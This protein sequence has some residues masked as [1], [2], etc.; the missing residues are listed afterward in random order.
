LHLTRV[1]IEE[2]FLNG[3]DLELSPGLNVLIGARGT[4]KTSVIEL[5]RYAL[6]AKNHT[7]T[8]KVRSLDHARAV[9]SD[10]EVTVNLSDALGFEHVVV[11]RGAEDEAPRSTGEFAPPIVLS[12]TEVETLGLSEAGRLSLIDGFVGGRTTLKSEE[13]STVSSTRS[14]YQEISTL[15][16]ELDQFGE[17]M[18]A[19]AALTAQ[20]A[21]LKKQQ[22]RIQGQSK[23]IQEKQA[24]LAKHNDNLADLSV[25]I[26]YLTRFRTSAEEWSKLIER[27]VDDDFAPESWDEELT[28]DPLDGLRER[29]VT[30]K[31]SAAL[32]VR[33]FSAL[34]SLAFSRTEKTAQQRIEQEKI[35]RTLRTELDKLAEGSGTL[36]RQI[37]TLQTQIAQAQSREKIVA[38][39]KRRLAVLRSKRDE[40][41]A[42]LQ[43]TRERRFEARAN[44]IKTLNKALSPHIRIELERSAQYQDYTKAITNA[45]RGSGMKYAELATALSQRV[46]PRE[47]IDSVDSG[48]FALLAEL[49]DIPKD[50]AARLIGHIR[51]F[52]C[53]EIATSDVD[54]NVRM[55]L[56]DGTEYKDITS[57]SAGQRCTVILSIVLQHKERTLVIDQPEDHLDNAFVATTVIKALRGR[58]KSGQV[59]LSTHNANIPVLGDADLVV[60][61]TSD[62]RNGFLQLAR[63]LEHPE[64]VEAI[65]SV[66]EG[67]RDAFAQRAHFY[68]AHKT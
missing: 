65:T 7:A 43:G 30:A 19:I 2:G 13:A 22:S 57:L 10:G 52:G 21:E 24:I 49:A 29:Y 61:L 67:G 55:S 8:S 59:I 1:Q 16:S 38:D 53:A 48:D 3:F 20:L 36:E 23:V 56:L 66:M 12:Q 33:D 62:G 5:I 54:D 41:L 40:L 44:I 28:D 11:T 6:A 31:R 25:R 15:E 14:I 63:P 45:L 9:L 60:Q 17:G 35:A 51:E 37:A 39:R 4:G 58:K 18:P 32:L 34:S 50:R 68:A 46:S 47:L 64:A 26:D 42:T 27:Q